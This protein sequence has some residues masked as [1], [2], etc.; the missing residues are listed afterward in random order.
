MASCLFFAVKARAKDDDI[1]ATSSIMSLKDP[2]Q[3]TRIETPCRSLSCRHNECFDGAVYLALQEQAPTWTCP[4][5]SKPAGWDNLVFD[6]FVEDI[7]QRTSKSQDSVTIEPDG[8][9]RLT[10]DNDSPDEKAET[11]QDRDQDDYE[12]YYND[13]DDDDDLVEISDFR[14]SG[15]P[16][17]MRTPNMAQTPPMMGAD[18]SLTGP[19]SAS[20]SNK[21]PREEV[22]DLTLDDDDEDDQPPVS[23]IKRPSFTSQASDSFRHAGSDH[24]S[25]SFPPPPRPNFPNGYSQFGNTGFGS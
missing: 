8:R 6:K 24:F 19:S 20:R 14:P 18:P 25:F 12:D 17:N 22:I 3:M 15:V 2:V 16:A 10:T 11:H 1:V 9:W 4:I 5:C 23:R 7:L 21:R 13:E